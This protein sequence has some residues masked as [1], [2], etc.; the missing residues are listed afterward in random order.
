MKFLFLNSNQVKSGE[1]DG[2][3]LPREYVLLCKF[4]GCGVIDRTHTLDQGFDYKSIDPIPNVQKTTITFDEL[5]D[6][7]GQEILTDA[8]NTD[9]VVKVFWS[10][11]IDSTA[12]LIALMKAADATDRRELLRVMLSVESMHEYPRF[13]QDH[14]K[15]KFKTV[16]VTHP[17]PTFLDP[18]AINVTGEH[19]DQ[20]FGSWLLEPYVKGGSSVLDYQDMLPLVLTEHLGNRHRAEQVMKFLEPQFAASPVPLKSLFDCFWWMSFSLKWQQVAL[21]L[22]VFRNEEVFKLHQAIVHFFRDS[23]FQVWSL[24]NPNARRALSWADYKAPAKE[25]ILRY[26]NDF[27]YYRTKRKELSLKRVIVKP[28]QRESYRTLIFMKEDFIPTVKLVERGEQW[29]S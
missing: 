5:C 28:E 8:A 15:K 19:G 13:F 10:G 27:D 1:L 9:R 14:I 20:L 7:I 12:A 11:G 21:R 6:T 22:Q 3:Q 23:R 4:L 25:Y 29:K 17:L 26:T 18:S 24:A 16:P 2:L